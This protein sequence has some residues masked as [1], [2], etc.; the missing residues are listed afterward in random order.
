MHGQNV[1]SQS[2]IASELGGEAL[3]PELAAMRLRHE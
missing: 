1:G 3:R 2:G